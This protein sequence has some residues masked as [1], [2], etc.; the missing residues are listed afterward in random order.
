[1]EGIDSF[2]VPRTPKATPEPSL[3]QQVEGDE[4]ARRRGPNGEPPNVGSF[5]SVVTARP[6][7]PYEWLLQ[8]Y[9]AKMLNLLSTRVMQFVTQVAGKFNKSA[10]DLLLD[11]HKDFIRYL[12]ESAPRSSDA[13]FLP[14]PAGNPSTPSSTS[15]LETIVTPEMLR[16]FQQITNVESS[17]YLSKQATNQFIA[18]ERLLTLPTMLSDIYFNAEL[19]SHTREAMLLVRQ[20]SKLNAYVGDAELYYYL[21]HHDMWMPLFANLVAALMFRDRRATYTHTAKHQ[22]AEVNQRVRQARQPFVNFY[23]NRAAPLR[24]A[25]SG[26][27]REP[28][29]RPIIKAEKLGVQAFTQ[30]VE[31]RFRDVEA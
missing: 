16:T 5:G 14:Q 12:E 23:I 11:V 18:L 10:S 30:A 19:T 3:L 22:F 13:A 21:L 4:Q 15:K 26:P 27:V 31:E 29:H 8:D 2:I 25:Q 17:M 20:D 7:Y 24:G 6:G 28:V 1:M 9:Q